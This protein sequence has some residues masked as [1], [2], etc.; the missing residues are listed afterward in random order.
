[1]EKFIR[2]LNYIIDYIIDYES[3]GESGRNLLLFAHA[4]QPIINEQDE[5]ITQLESQIKTLTH[6]QYPKPTDGPFD[7]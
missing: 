2:D 7:Q 6:N 3:D 1:M 5:R 4:I